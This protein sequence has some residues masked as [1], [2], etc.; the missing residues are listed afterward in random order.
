MRLIGHG[1][2]PVHSPNLPGTPRVSVLFGGQADQPAD[3]GMVIVEV[4]PGAG[5]PPHKHHGSDVI[6]MPIRGAVRVTKGDQ[7]LD[8]GVGD[9]LF[10]DKDEAVG[11]ANTGAEPAELMVA[12]GP[13]A[14]VST[15]SRWPLAEPAPAN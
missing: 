13:P 12:A 4:P 8:V 14:F 5:M 6:L 2:A 7:T 15:V 10:I 9:A 3:V 11:L 1:T